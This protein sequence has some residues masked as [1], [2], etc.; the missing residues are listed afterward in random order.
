MKDFFE[1]NEEFEELH[2]EWK[3]VEDLFDLREF[4]EHE[5]DGMEVEYIIVEESAGC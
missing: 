5:A 4:L 2:S 1:P 3:K